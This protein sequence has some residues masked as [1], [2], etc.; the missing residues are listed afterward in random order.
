MA[1][2][3]I[4]SMTYALKKIHLYGIILP[5]KGGFFEVSPFHKSLILLGFLGF[6]RF[7]LWGFCGRLLTFAGVWVCVWVL[8]CLFG[9][10]RVGLRANRGGVGSVGVAGGVSVG[11]CV[12][13]SGHQS[14][15]RHRVRLSACRLVGQSVAHSSGHFYF[16]RNRGVGGWEV[17]GAN[18]RIAPPPTIFFGFGALVRLAIHLCICVFVYL[19]IV[20]AK[21]R[22]TLFNGVGIIVLLGILF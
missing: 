8:R 4:K 18:A 10:V 15:A 9:W 17:G 7:V 21:K 22:L 5:Q 3:Q 12:G 1:K 20:R 16:F 19:Y 13:Q 6:L 14:R 11:P 2:N